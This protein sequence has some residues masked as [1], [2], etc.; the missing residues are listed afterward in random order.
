METSRLFA[1]L[2]HVLHPYTLLPMGVMLGRVAVFQSSPLPP[3]F[4]QMLRL[5]LCAPPSTPLPCLPCLRSTCRSLSRTPVE[6]D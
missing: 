5:D 4:S 6:E 1:H 2:E 3:G